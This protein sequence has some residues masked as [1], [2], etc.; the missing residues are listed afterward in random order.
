MSIHTPTK[1]A[2]DSLDQEIV[3]ARAHHAKSFRVDYVITHLFP[4]PTLGCLFYTR[5]LEHA[6]G[7]QTI[8][9]D[10][11][12]DTAVICTRSIATLAQELG[13]GHDTTQKYV[14]IYRALGLLKK[15]KLMGKL[16]FVMRTGIYHPPDLLEANLTY[17][18]R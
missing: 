3:P 6:S 9:P 7:E 16:A 14:V 15:R 18:L 8:L 13:V 12:P 17:L 11:P 10:E 5:F 4:S 2:E 1:D